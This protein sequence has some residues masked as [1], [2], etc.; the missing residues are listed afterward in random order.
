MAKP[1]ARNHAHR[2]IHKQYAPLTHQNPQKQMVPA[3]VLTQSKP[4]SITAVRPVSDVVPKFKVTRPRHATPIVTKTNS[5][6]RRHITYFPSPKASNSPPKVTAVKASMVNAAP[7]SGGS[8]GGRGNDG[9][10]KSDASFTGKG[11]ESSISYSSRKQMS[12]SES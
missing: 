6:I 11:M 7:A 2:G 5:P 12:P 3:A 10:S 4:V 9:L 8:G 1:T